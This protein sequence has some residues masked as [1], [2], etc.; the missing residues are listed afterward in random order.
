MHRIKLLT[1]NIDLL[2]LVVFPHL[3]LMSKIIQ[4]IH[5]QR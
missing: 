1:Y 4:F 2:A 3:P 5:M